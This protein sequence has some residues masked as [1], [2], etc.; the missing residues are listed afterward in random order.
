MALA[1]DVGAFVGWSARIT[2]G[3][4]A[5]RA[6]TKR[7][8]DGTISQTGSFTIRALASDPD[9]WARELSD[10]INSLASWTGIR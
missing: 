5:S 8:I 4:V 2:S 9:R 3:T 7:A 1:A 10:P 6:A